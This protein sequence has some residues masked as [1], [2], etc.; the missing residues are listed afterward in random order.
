[1]VVKAQIP[2]QRPPPK[3]CS[4]GLCEGL[5][6][7][8]SLVHDLPKKTRHVWAHTCRC[9]LRERVRGYSSGRDHSP[10]PS[11]EGGD[12]TLRPFWASPPSCKSP[13]T[14]RGE[15][16]RAARRRKLGSPASDS[17]AEWEFRRLLQT[18]AS[19]ELAVRIRL[20]GEFTRRR[21]PPG[22]PSSPRARQVPRERLPRLPAL[23]AVP[24]CRAGCPGSGCVRAA[25]V[26]QRV[27]GPRVVVPVLAL[28]AAVA[29][30]EVDSDVPRVRIL[31][32]FGQQARG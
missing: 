12:P 6:L 25:P 15:G 27:V 17:G 2:C 7:P 13:T 10:A 30:R 9:R 18:G 20:R 32:V 14:V 26:A 29:N 21:F 16:L 3:Q 4:A 8:K 23:Q 24:D 11:L 5:Y 1:M 31:P 28:R 22:S 19:R